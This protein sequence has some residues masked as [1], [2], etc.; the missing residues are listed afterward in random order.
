MRAGKRR[1]LI[2]DDSAVM[3]SLLRSVIGTAPSFEVAGTAIDG[4]AALAALETLKPEVVLLDV[5]MPR[6]GGLETLRRLRSLGYSMPVIMCSSLTQRGARVTIEA[7]A[8]GASDYVAKPSGQVNR[9][10]AVAALSRDLLPKIEVLANKLIGETVCADRTG[11]D[12]QAPPASDSQATQAVPR[13]LVI[14]VSTGGPAA[15]D[16]LLP[17]LPEN[18]PLPVLVVQHMSEL[19]TGLMAERLDQRCP[20]RVCEA[21][22]GEVVCPGKIHLA[23]GNWHLEVISAMSKGGRGALHLTQAPL[24][25]HCRPAVDVLFRSAANV[26]GPG[27]LAVVLTGMGSD[28]LAGSRAVRTH[29]GTVLVQDRASSTVWGMPAAVANEGIAHRVLPL[30]SLAGEILRLT[31]RGTRSAH[32]RPGKA[33]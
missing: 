4:E 12:L 29:G 30:H 21:T 5:E 23:R 31:G 28:G 25:N 7:L 13:V 24:E 22:E 9:E 8:S 6:M 27:V 11:H 26:F 14:G 15:L 20:L 33:R 19:F 3:R 2:V 10:A 17:A 32:E 1:I 16:V 18:F